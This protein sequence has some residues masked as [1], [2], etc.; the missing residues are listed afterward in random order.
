M[1]LEPQEANMAKLKSEI[2]T[3]YKNYEPP[4]KPNLSKEEK[5]AVSSLRERSNN[6]SIIIKE[7]DKSKSF[8]VMEKATYTEKTQQILNDARNYEMS[9]MTAGELERLTLA[10]LEKLQASDIKDEL[11]ALLRPRNTRLAELYALPK[12][13]KINMPL[14][15]VVSACD[16]PTTAVSAHL[17]NTQDALDRLNQTMAS[18]GPTDSI[19]LV[20]MDVV[21]LYPNIPIAEGIDCV[22]GFIQEHAAEIDLEAL[23]TFIEH[24][25]RQHPTIQFTYESTEGGRAL[26]FLDVSFT[27][28]DGMVKHRLYRKPSDSCINIDY[29]SAVPSSTKYAVGR[30]HYT[31]ARSYSSCTELR[32]ESMQMTDDLLRMNNYPDEAITTSRYRSSVTKST[33]VSTVW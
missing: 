5:L 27:V 4:R 13:H 15:P 6:G 19:I 2:L 31:R 22:M 17:S 32:T 7:S 18:L 1:G 33:I 21:G 8:V 16:T 11:R 23:R 3:L 10:E 29:T 26:P 30:Q 28:E 14:R 20:S 12:T 25:N 24:C 9:T